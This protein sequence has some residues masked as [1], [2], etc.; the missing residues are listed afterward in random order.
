MNH[1][2]LTV[3]QRVIADVMV[4]EATARVFG[5]SATEWERNFFRPH[6]LGGRLDAEGLQ[7]ILFRDAESRSVAH[8]AWLL[9]LTGW[10]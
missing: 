9:P 1:E 6:L 7:E 5:R 8:S 10:N 4:N 2:L 3:P